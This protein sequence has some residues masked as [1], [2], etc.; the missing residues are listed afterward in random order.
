MRYPALRRATFAV[1]ELRIL[2]GSKDEQG[3][4]S[5]QRQ[6]AEYWRNGNS[7]LSVCRDMHGSYIQYL[8]VMGVIESLIDEGQ[9][10]QNN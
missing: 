10:A 1:F 9:P 3:D 6:P 7:V 8:F 2:P 5:D 4:S